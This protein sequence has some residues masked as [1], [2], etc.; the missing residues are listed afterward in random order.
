MSLSTT[1]LVLAAGVA[2]GAYMLF[3]K[4]TLSGVSSTTP[5]RVEDVLMQNPTIIPTQSIPGLTPSHDEIVK[6]Q[7]QMQTGKLSD[8]QTGIRYGA[9]YW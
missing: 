9:Q 2:F 6:F 3:S 7:H 1:Q 5:Q 4:Q 8:P